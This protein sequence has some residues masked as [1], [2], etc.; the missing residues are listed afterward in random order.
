MP[1]KTFL[2]PNQV[3]KIRSL[4]C[5]AVAELI[6][7]VV[8]VDRGAPQVLAGEALRSTSKCRHEAHSDLRM[9]RK[10]SSHETRRNRLD[11]AA[12]QSP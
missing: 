10:R 11:M 12:R 6:L 8:T 7:R 5:I 4:G 9:S 2:E 1:D 3:A